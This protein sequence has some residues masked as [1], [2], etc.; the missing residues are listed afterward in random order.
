MTTDTTNITELIKLNERNEIITTADSLK[1]AEAYEK[2]HDNVIRDIRNLIKMCPEL[3]EDFEESDYIN[4]RGKTYPM[5]KM[6][7]KGFMLLVMGFSG[8]KAL[9]FKI[10]IV[11]AFFAMEAEILRRREQQP[12]HS[13][14]LRMALEQIEAQ[15]VKENQDNGAGVN[16]QPIP[17]HDRNNQED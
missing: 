13:E 1:V 7:R 16:F 8:E 6:T 3:G 11:D 9:I 4:S 2:R 17:C 5:Y 15:T 12:K 10:R 14:L